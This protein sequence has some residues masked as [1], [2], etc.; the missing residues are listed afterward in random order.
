MEKQRG[1]PDKEDFAK[2]NAG[3]KLKKS[4]LGGNSQTEKAV[5]ETKSRKESRMRIVLAKLQFW[6]HC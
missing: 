3:E 4:G 1:D 5:G 6:T 2:T